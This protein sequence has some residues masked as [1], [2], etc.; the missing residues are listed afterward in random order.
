LRLLF[1]RKPS[2]PAPAAPPTP[3]DRWL[4]YARLGAWAATALL[5]AVTIVPLGLEWSAA[6]EGGDINLTTE[7]YTAFERGGGFLTYDFSPTAAKVLRDRIDSDRNGL[8]DDREFF[9]YQNALKEK[10]R[11]LLVVRSFQLGGARVDEWRGFNGV[12]VNASDPAHLH[13]T[14]SGYWVEHDADVTLSRGPL[15]T[16]AYGNLTGSERIHERTVVINGG[17]ATLTPSSGSARMLRVPGGVVVVSTHDYPAAAA[18]DST[19]P[20]VRFVRFSVLDSSLVL[21]APLS[22]AY[23]LGV[24]GARREQEA[25]RQA[26]VVPFHRALSA[27]FLLLLI[28]YFGG[29]LG[30]IVWGGGVAL[31]VAGLL[32]AYRFYPAE[33]A[34]GADLGAP[35]ATPG[36]PTPEAPGAGA[37]WESVRA[38]DENAAAAGIAAAAAM[39]SRAH[40]PLGSPEARA[41]LPEPPSAGLAAAREMMPKAVTPLELPDE[42]TPRPGGREAAPLGGASSPQAS[43]SPAPSPGPSAPAAPASIR[44]RCPGCKHYFEAQGTRPL[45]V[46]CPHCGRHGVLR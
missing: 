38:P 23:L 22:I 29:I 41:K 42:D 46:T 1:W 26:R 9:E 17:L 27:L 24:A 5:L 19:S 11:G 35:L 15:V 16:I 30:P 14:I 25:T 20:D 28:V 4:L 43:P 12:A 3:F 8:V 44:V 33:R 37:E 21:L 32:L 36:R 45:S 39:L 2:D 7:F 10:V 40:T 13:I 31:G 6:N 34:P 18:N